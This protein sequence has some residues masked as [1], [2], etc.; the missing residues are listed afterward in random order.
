MARN[1]E[2]QRTPDVRAERGFT[3]REVCLLAGA[4]GVSVLG[5]SGCGEDERD[6]AGFDEAGT[7]TGLAPD[8]EVKNYPVSLKL[9]A[10]ET[11]RWF[12]G[13]SAALTKEEQEGKNHL[14][15]YILRYQKQQ[16]RADVDIS[17]EY[18]ESG[19]LLRMARTGFSG[20]DGILAFSSTVQA[21]NEAGTVEGGEGGY[22]S[23][24]MGTNFPS[25]FMFV[26]A[27]GSSAELPPAR[28]IDGEPSSDGSVNR[29][30]ELPSFDGLIAMVGD[31]DRFETQALNNM[32]LRE[33]FYTSEDGRSG[34]YSE[35]IVD[36]LW[37]YPTQD[38][39][40]EGV[41]SGKCQ[42]G[43]ADWQQPGKRYPQIERYDGA[44]PVTFPVKAA[45]LAGSE[46][47]AVMRD[48]FEFI[49]RCT[50]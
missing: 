6:A 26:R 7:R 27:K 3:R 31:E 8:T 22:L 39:A 4:L 44:A 5:L 19:E 25:Q 11:F 36:K 14:E 23:R 29:V 49:T 45:A 38:A 17:V 47:P 41:A 10:D 15:E 9:Y 12:S 16:N 46:N 21:G 43:V 30:Q 18:V 28:T 35:D 37:V 2:A 1:N 48:F 33:G 40:M 32:L 13:G 24:D 42:L 20:G 50:D 34:T